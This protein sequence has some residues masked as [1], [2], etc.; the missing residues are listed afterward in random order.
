MCVFGVLGKHRLSTRQNGDE[1]H[2][3]QTVLNCPRARLRYAPAR[4]TD[5][6]VKSIHWFSDQRAH[7]CHT[8][9]AAWQ[10]A[11]STDSCGST[12]GQQER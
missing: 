2:H 1:F 11:A 9:F 7:P 3:Q 12:S 6:S 5:L 4:E 8:S 10:W